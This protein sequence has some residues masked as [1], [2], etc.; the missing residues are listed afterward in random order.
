MLDHP[1]AEV[2]QVFKHLRVDASTTCTENSLPGICQFGEFSFD[3]TASSGKP[4]EHLSIFR[5]ML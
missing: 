4:A 1:Q 5:L 2:E 3:P